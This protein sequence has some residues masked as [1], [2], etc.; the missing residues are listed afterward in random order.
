MAENWDLELGISLELG[1]WSWGPRVS[2]TSL[3]TISHQQTPSDRFFVRLRP[4]ASGAW[5]LVLL[6]ML[7][8]EVWNFGAAAVCLIDAYR[9]AVIVCANDA[10][11]GAG[12]ADFFGGVVV[13][14]GGAW[15]G[16]R[17]FGGN[18]V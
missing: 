9:P 1:A 2:R 11:M 10:S 13:F 3:V 15:R 17:L 14:I 12:G 4:A 6:W 5:S 8:L 16:V 18:G 7:A